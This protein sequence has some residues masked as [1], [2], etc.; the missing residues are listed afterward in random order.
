MGLWEKTPKSFF[1]GISLACV[2]VVVVLLIVRLPG[3]PTNNEEKIT[4]AKGDTHVYFL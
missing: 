2:V 4:E 3:D 1:L